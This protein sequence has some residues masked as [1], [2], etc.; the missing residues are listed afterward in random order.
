MIAK[1]PPASL[2]STS[3]AKVK[4]GLRPTEVFL[5]QAIHAPAE[6][7]LDRGGKRVRAD[8]IQIA[9]RAGGG[10]GVPPQA[11]I[12]FI[13]WLHSGSL[14]ID[15]IQD[16]STCRRGRES[17]H[18]KYGVP[19][20][21]NIA[22]WMYFAALEKLSEIELEPRQTTVLL[23]RTLSVIKQCH[24]GQGLDLTLRVENL[25]QPS[26]AELV[27]NISTS[28]TGALTGLAAWL[29][30]FTAGAPPERCD[31]ICSAGRDLGIGLQMQNDFVEVK[32]SATDNV[33]SEDLANHRVTWP[34]AWMAENLPEI[35]YRRMV[36]L[37]GQSNIH[38][39]NLAQEIVGRIDR[40][41][42]R[43]INMRL[44]GSAV[45]LSDL[46]ED[47]PTIEQL[48][49]LVETLELRYA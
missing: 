5:Q 20:A 7:F 27:E 39:R 15:D 43:A 12:D 10:S 36:K 24:E 29:G 47:A 42:V 11:L 2:A 3:L 48:N 4:S 16:G 18:I 31:Q 32:R 34:W 37:L 30:A 44:V 1:L 21:I 14:A 25:D 9:Y 40:V 26:V 8:L 23:R 28:K 33:P 41:A 6:D 22:N 46:L 38:F 35:E 49:K 17:L 19:Q 45:E 13:E